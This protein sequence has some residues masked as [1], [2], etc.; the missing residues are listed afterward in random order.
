MTTRIRRWVLVSVSI[1]VIMLVFAAIWYEL[2]FYE[3]AYAWL[4]PGAT[5]AEVLK[6]FGKP[7]NIDASCLPPSWDGEA[8]DNSSMPCVEQFRYF[9]RFSIGEWVIGF[10]KNGKVVAGK[11]SRRMKSD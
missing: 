2:T 8:V 11:S 3:R 6:H 1:L 4:K 5:K 10:D 7:G 9:H